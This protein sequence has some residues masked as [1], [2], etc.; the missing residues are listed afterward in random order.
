MFHAFDDVDGTEAWAFIPSD[1]FRGTPND[2]EGLV[3]LT[4]QVGGL[5]FYEHRY[6]V[7]A[8]PRIVD[9]APGG[10]WKTMLVS[11]MGKGGKSYFAIDVTDPASVTDEAS[12]ASK[13]MWEFRDAADLGYTFGRANIIKTRA[14][15]GKWVVVLP[16][17]YNNAS[18]LGMIFFLDA[19]NGTLLKK[20]STGTGAP[21]IRP[22]SRICQAT[23]W[24]PVTSSPS[25]STPATCSAMSGAST[26]RT[27]T[28]ATGRCRSSRAS[29]P[30]SR[31]PPSRQSA[32]TRSTASIGGYSS[33]PGSCSTS[34][35]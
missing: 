8:T 2:K 29:V 21:P 33:G 15:G 5:P 17:G 3:G 11:G 14:F 35:T 28:T 1:L 23:C 13:V 27:R 6:Y 10:T 7:N 31:S 25:R 22:G 16:A 32:S 9:A 18:G 34:R 20:M 26:S 30:R 24:M 12:A 19:A 4:Y